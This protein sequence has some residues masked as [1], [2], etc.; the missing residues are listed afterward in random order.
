M[1]VDVYR[2]K[3]TQRE[4]ELDKVEM[5]KKKWNLRNKN[6]DQKARRSRR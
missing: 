6:S 3:Y 1:V 4:D 2:D 5:L